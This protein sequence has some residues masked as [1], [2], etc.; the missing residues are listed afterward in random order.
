MRHVLT[1]LLVALTLVL[2]SFTAAAQDAVFEVESLNDGLPGSRAELDLE[3][4]QSSMEAFLEAAAAKDWQTAAQVLDLRDIDRAEQASLG[5]ELAQQLSVILDRK[6]VLSWPSLIERPDG[7]DESASEKSPLA[8]QPRKSLLLGL[9]DLDDRSVAVRLNRLK[10]GDEPAVWMF[11]R[12][13]VSNIPALYAEHGPTRFEEALPGWLRAEA[14]FDLRLWELVALPVMVLMAAAAAY[15]TWKALGWLRSRRPDSIGAALVYALRL[16]ATLIALALTVQAMTDRIFVVSSVVDATLEPILTL[17]WV[18]ALMILMVNAIDRVL[19]LLTPEEVSDLTD[20]ENAA[21]R[22]RVTALSAARRIVIVLA[23]IAGTGLVFASANI[24][25][26]LGFS[27][28][29]GA[30]ALTLVLG[31]AAREVLGN[32]LASLQIALNRSARVGDQLVY[33]GELVYVER[34]HFTFVQLRVWDHTRL[35]VP[36][37]KFV[38]EE[39]FNRNLVEPGMI[40]NVKL[41]LSN[42]IDMDRLRERFDDYIRT[43][44]AIQIEERENDTKA[45]IVDQDEHGILVRFTI[46]VPDPQQGW[47]EEVA[48]RE[49]MIKAAQEMEAE[50]DDDYVPHMGLSPNPEVERLRRSAEVEDDDAA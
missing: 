23:V 12:Q 19:D 5:P 49:A 4:P 40:R 13:T 37:L 42:R 21:H 3:T 41:K 11:S 20:P 15:A 2:A 32:I 22:S 8:G 30:G 7:L 44:D 16:P 1:R 34:I 38:S 27:L 9:L 45:L 43:R 26:L 10:P 17:I 6:V 18:A 31:F 48:L 39:F 25:R 14:L 36:V 50:D 35:I 46:S 28:L 47:D 24:F 33:E 29:A